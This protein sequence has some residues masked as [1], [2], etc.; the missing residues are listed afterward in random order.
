MAELSKKNQK[1]KYMEAKNVCGEYRHQ[2]QTK[3]TFIPIRSVVRILCWV[4]NLG[5]SAI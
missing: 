1:K 4:R 3:N 5:H 2:N